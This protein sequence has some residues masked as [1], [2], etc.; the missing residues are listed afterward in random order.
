MQL[1]QNEFLPDLVNLIVKTRVN[2]TLSGTRANELV[3]AC[4][5]D[6]T[7]WGE[8]EGLIS[9]DTLDVSDYSATSSIL[10][11]EKPT[12]DEQ[13]LETT[14]KK[15]IKVTLNKYLMKGAF[16]DEGSL[17]AC[18]S[19]IEQM[20]EK[21]K[22]I[23][24]YKKIVTAYAGWD[25]DTEDHLTQTI[26][27]KLVDP[28]GLTGDAKLKVDT[29]NALEIYRVIR[30]YALDMQAPSR[31]YN[32]LEFEEMY[33][34]DNLDFIVNGKFDELINTSAYAQLL[35]SDKLNN[36]KLYDKSII[37]PEKQF[38][39]DDVKT[40]YIGWLVSK[41]KYQ[42]SPRF[43]VNT[44]FFDASTL[45]IQEYLHFWLNSGF[46]R[47]LAGVRLIAQFVAPEPEIVEA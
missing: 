33:N 12:I 22:L 21:T 38:A 2:D 26:A 15:F 17:M 32:E 23:Y 6:G 42:I 11:S 13:Q 25:P 7:E 28:T 3:D 29:Q 35:N 4:M 43:T 45:N 9:V 19:A 41:K 47:G 16:A 10:T 1:N 44:E 18:I 40:Y 34:A 8:G 20:L 37:I 39:S 14:D 27:V 36:I 5:V 46:A 30:K 24:M 31:D